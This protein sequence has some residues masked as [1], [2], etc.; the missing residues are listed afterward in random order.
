[1][2]NGIRL[3]VNVAGE[4]RTYSGFLISSSEDTLVVARYT[5]FRFSGVVFLNR[6]ATAAR[7]VEPDSI[8][9]F[10]QS[11]VNKLNRLE[12]YIPE[13]LIKARSI[14]EVLRA[15]LILQKIIIIEGKNLGEFEVCKVTALSETQAIVD[16]LF[17]DGAWDKSGSR[18]KIKNILAL[19]IM[20]PY[21]TT[22]E[23]YLALGD[24]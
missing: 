1:M 7:V 19:T 22:I 14:S 12:T 9:T 15:A 3:D 17:S 23:E 21:C 5:D 8:S 20:D 4:G 10:F 18:L 16:I 13:S 6:K 24:S 2:K 11:V